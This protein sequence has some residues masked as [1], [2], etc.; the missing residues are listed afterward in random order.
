MMDQAQQ[1]E[2]RAW[3]GEALEGALDSDSP[4][5][6]LF[7]AGKLPALQD[8]VDGLQANNHRDREFLDLT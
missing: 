3:I 4:I 2:D 5:L 1:H 8:I 7:K 6:C